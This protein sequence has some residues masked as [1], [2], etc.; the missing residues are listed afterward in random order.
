MACG[1]VQGMLQK[2]DAPLAVAQ[3]ES[4]DLAAHAAALVVPGQCSS[5]MAAL[6]AVL[7]YAAFDYQLLLGMLEM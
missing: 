5:S 4:Q 2:C 6:K 3:V 1:S 7:L